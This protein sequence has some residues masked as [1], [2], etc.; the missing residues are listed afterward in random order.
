[1][2]DPNSLA[3]DA[4]EDAVTSAEWVR[5]HFLAACDESREDQPPDVDAYL[6]RIPEPDRSRL[7]GAGVGGAGPPAPPRPRR[8]GVPGPRTRTAPDATM[9]YPPRTSGPRAG[10][11]HYPA[12]KFFAGPLSGTSEQ[13][14]D[15]FRSRPPSEEEPMGLDSKTS[16]SFFGHF[17]SFEAAWS[18]ISATTSVTS[19]SSPSVPRSPAPM[20][21][22]P[23]RNSDTPNGTG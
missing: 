18:S 13:A 19:C 23:C 3:P 2:S 16:A 21:L 8:H 9:D 14:K 10:Q 11:S 20:T 15:S 17:D 22:S 1:M 12:E 6:S 4:D 7:R 5:R